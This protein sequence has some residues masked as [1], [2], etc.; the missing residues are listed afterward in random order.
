MPYVQKT[1]NL[2]IISFFIVLLQQTCGLRFFYFSY[3]NGQCHAVS[4]KLLQVGALGKL[5]SPSRKSSL[6]FL[7]LFCGAYGQKGTKDALMASQLPHLYSRLDVWPFI[8]LITFFGIYQLYCLIIYFFGFY[9][10]A[11]IFFFFEFLHLL[12]A[13][14][15]STSFTSSKEIDNSHEMMLQNM[16]SQMIGLQIFSSSPSLALVCSYI[17]N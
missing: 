4:G 3:C 11:N 17:Y 14:A 13:F 12:D 2:S 10:R 16:W 5:R 6:W 15:I 1:L 9:W 7:L 8:P